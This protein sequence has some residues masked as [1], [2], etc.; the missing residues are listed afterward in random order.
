MTTDLTRDPT[1]TRTLVRSAAQW[2]QTLDHATAILRP[3]A[4]PALRVLLGFVFIWFGL[5]KVIGDSPVAALVART[6]P[7]ASPHVVVPA[8]GAFEVVLGTLLL[9]NVAA[10]V[11]LPVL[12]LHLAGTF[13]TF[14][15]APDLM[16]RGDDPILLTADGEFVLKNVI[17]I[18]AALTVFAHLGPRVSPVRIDPHPCEDRSRG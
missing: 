14:V 1:G 2:E 10:R 17:V 3:V 15:M 8:L 9:L 11:V 18:A 6:L 7:V 4:L 16:F 12:A 13:L 5:L